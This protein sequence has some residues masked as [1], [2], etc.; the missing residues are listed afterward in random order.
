MA[1][2]NTGTRKEDPMK[3]FP[4]DGLF[5]LELNKKEINMTI[6]D[7]MYNYDDKVFTQID[8]FKTYSLVE[9]NRWTY[10]KPK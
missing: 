7:C 2:N 9:I 1:R 10:Q 3:E 4:I 8:D 6:T 5:T